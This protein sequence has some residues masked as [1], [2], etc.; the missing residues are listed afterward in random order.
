MIRLLVIVPYPELKE[1]VDYVLAHHP[2]R[3]RLDADVQVMTVEDTPDVPA[4]EYDAIIARGYS[5]Q[6]TIARYKN[7]PTIC[8]DISG[9]DMLR[10]V[11]ECQ[12]LF[13]PGKIA[14]C[15]FESRLF[16]AEEICRMVGVNAAV[17]APVLHDDL[18]K[19]MERILASGCD[20]VV[21]GYSACILAEH[22]G[23]P[24]VVIKT[25]QDTVDRIRGE[26]V[27]S[28]MYKTIIYSSED[29]LLYV[30]RNGVIRVRNRVVRQMNG[31][32]SLMDRK[33]KTVLPYL[34]K[35]FETV[36]TG[37]LEQSGRI[38]TIPGTKTRVSVSCRP[39]IANKE[40]SGAVI[41]LSD[42]TLIQNLESQI[43]RKLSERG[44]KA[45][46]TF[47]DI[48]HESGT[49]KETIETARRY[50][51]TDSNVIIV[52][53]TGTGKEL[54][55]QS[56]HNSSR[57]KN[58]P[59]VA[60][61]CAAL[62]ENL[63]ESELFGYVEG[64]FT[65]TS[66]GGKMGLF[67][68]AHGGTLFLDEVEEI[69]LSTQSKLLR[70]LQEKQVRRIGDNKVIDID[71]RILSATNKSITRLSEE[72]GFRK[73]LMYR[74]D[75]LRLFLP[76]L[77]QRERDV[78]FLF[79]HLLGKLCQDMGVKAPVTEPEALELLY[80]YPFMGNIRELGNIAER[81]LVLG[82]GSILTKEDLSRALY[83]RDLEEAGMEERKTETKESG[84]ACTAFPADPLR[85]E[86]ERILEALERCEG[87][88]VRAAGLLGMDR[89]TLWRKMKKY[90]L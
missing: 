45:R 10:A 6:K 3:E 19:T 75:V 24:S 65:G 55:A 40:I 71:V 73:D 16:E 44:L 5:A 13:H 28:Q 89:S 66:R 23:I 41:C 88:R 36:M 77:R 38:L 60:I 87:S 32:V 59:F 80:Q 54:F 1:I 69:S 18:E 12:K 43:R 82:D 39:V 33:L 53:E 79:C 17:F 68:Q 74:L 62:P 35:D 81:A 76:P 9:Y 20:A 61:N 29:G 70:T 47:D 11:I 90:N 7:I 72:G 30:D 37:G 34:Y 57:R 49:M 52:G 2:E 21:G 27:I 56:I 4:D 42:I 14:I 31:D 85:P 83:P 63:L 48:L 15:G 58:G 78:E 86:R 51:A 25:G 8:L 64:A 50:A 22:R 26:R 46:Y 67:E 84:T